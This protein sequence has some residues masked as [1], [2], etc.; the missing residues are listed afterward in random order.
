M[1]YEHF[2]QAYARLGS[3]PWLLRS[4]GQRALGGGKKNGLILAARAAAPATRAF[5]LRWDIDSTRPPSPPAARRGPTPPPEPVPASTDPVPD[6][7]HLALSRRLVGVQVIQHHMR[8][9]LVFR[10]GGAAEGDVASRRR[11]WAE[12]ICSCVLCA[13]LR[14][15]LRPRAM[16]ADRQHY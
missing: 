2:P 9:H 15:R 4:R 1:R 10:K 14:R 12:L 11:G 13:L 5:S 16:Q 3:P 6:T 8:C 7:T